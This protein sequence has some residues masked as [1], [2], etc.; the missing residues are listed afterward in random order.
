MF[1]ILLLLCNGLKVIL[2]V[3]VSI[4]V[5]VNLGV[6]VMLLVVGVGVIGLVVGFGV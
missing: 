4:G 3:I 1:M 5:L 6:N 2:V